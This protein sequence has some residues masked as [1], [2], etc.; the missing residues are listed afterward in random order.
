MEPRNRLFDDL[1]KVAGSAAGSLSGLKAEVEARA[2]QRLDDMMA[3]LELVTREDFEA[4][5]AVVAKAREDQERLERRIAQ[6]EATVA[7][8]QAANPPKF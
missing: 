6:L 8:L 7:R 2:R 3:R 5:L 1:A 4:V